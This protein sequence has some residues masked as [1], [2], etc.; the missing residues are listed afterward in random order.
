MYWEQFRLCSI[1]WYLMNRSGHWLFSP[2]KTD[3][4]QDMPIIWACWPCNQTCWQNNLS[5]FQT[6]WGILLYSHYWQSQ[7]NVPMLGQLSQTCSSI[8]DQ[9][10]SQ[11]QLCTAAAWCLWHDQAVA[12]GNPSHYSPIFE[13]RSTGCWFMLRHIVAPDKALLLSYLIQH[14]SAFHMDAFMAKVLHNYCW[15]SVMG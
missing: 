14:A 4:I 9:F 7:T 5:S 12:H 11:Q 1:F 15:L 6:F 13:V 8:I 10:R 3:I 2:A